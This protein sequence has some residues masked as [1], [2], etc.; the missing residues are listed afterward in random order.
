MFLAL[1]VTSAYNSQ[2][3]VIGSSLTFKGIEAI[4]TKKLNESLTNLEP[5]TD[6]KFLKIN[7][8]PN[9]DYDYSSDYYHDI[10]KKID[11]KEKKV[12]ESFDIEKSKKK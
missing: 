7:K 3:Q 10:L 5:Y 9:G 11:K 6:N 4:L 1:Y 12:S 8:A 2:P